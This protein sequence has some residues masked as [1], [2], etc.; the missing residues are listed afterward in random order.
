MW[1]IRL[2]VIGLGLFLLKVLWDMFF[3]KPETKQTPAERTD[4]VKCEQCGIHIPQD[5]A[6]NYQQEDG[7]AIFFCGQE[8]K[9]I[10]L[11]S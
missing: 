3:K 8:H 1:V 2:L 4:M 7:Q 9:K 5:Q 10:F 6:I 11:D